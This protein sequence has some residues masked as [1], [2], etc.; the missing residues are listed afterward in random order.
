MS[1]NIS[2]YSD[3][4]HNRPIERFD[5]LEIVVCS[6]LKKLTIYNLGSYE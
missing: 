2:I 5:K 1:K 6:S 3:F 4:G